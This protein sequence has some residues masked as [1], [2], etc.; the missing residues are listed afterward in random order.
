M[1]W[2]TDVGGLR[3]SLFWLSI[4]SHTFPLPGLPFPHLLSGDTLTD[5][6]RMGSAS[7]L[8]LMIA[9]Q[10]KSNKMDSEGYGFR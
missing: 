5:K 6:D 8:D 9:L 1:V 2:E 10:M 4:L 3:S 7:N